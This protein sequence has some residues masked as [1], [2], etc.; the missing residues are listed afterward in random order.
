MV[1]N[2]RTLFLIFG[3]LFFFSTTS[4]CADRTDRILFTGNDVEAKI[5]DFD[6]S[7]TVVVSFQAALP[8]DA[9]RPPNTAGYGEPFFT[10][11]RISAIY[12]NNMLNNWYQS[13]EMNTVLP[14]I[15][16]EL[17]NFKR[18]ITYGGSMG[19]WAALTFAKQ[20]NAD[21]VI[22]FGPQVILEKW[23]YYKTFQ[24]KFN[25]QTLFPI[26]AIGLPKKASIFA[27]YSKFHDHDRTAIEGDLRTL[28]MN[29]G[30]KN[31]YAYPIPI[32]EHALSKDLQALGLLGEML[33]NSMAE[34]VPALNA[35]LLE[36]NEGWEK[37]L[38][39]TYTDQKLYGKKT[40]LLAKQIQQLKD[41]PND[42]GNRERLH[43]T[44]R[45]RNYIIPDQLLVEAFHAATEKDVRE[46]KNTRYGMR[47]YYTAKLLFDHYSPALFSAIAIP[48]DVLAKFGKGPND[49]TIALIEKRVDKLVNNPNDSKN[50]EHLSY[51]IAS[52]NFTLPDALVL[53][54]FKAA[55]ETDARVIK[56]LR[57][58]GVRAYLLAKQ[59]LGSYRDVIRADESIHPSIRELFRL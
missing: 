40:D 3:F 45:D 42:W 57:F 39:H 34:N 49:R 6:D 55:A 47:A 44:I 30:L 38:K 41:Q 1:L 31:F 28:Q 4:S 12:V 5:I 2:S 54:I 18:V 35:T 52:A 19:G 17:A 13:E 9:R 7:D 33:Q 46:E 16:K 21:T 51:L 26:E 29:A 27:F 53:K 59:I 36:G 43:A 56:K 11:R 10:K 14:L 8:T 22:V 23:P 37:V 48:S 58:H 24:D 20:L 32:P 50:L 25:F 15:E